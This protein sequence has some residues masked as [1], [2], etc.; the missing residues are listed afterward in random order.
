MVP[1]WVIMI[2]RHNKIHQFVSVSYSW[3]GYSY[4]MADLMTRLTLVWPILSLGAT[5]PVLSVA[6]T[7]WRAGYG[8]DRSGKTQK[9]CIMGSTVDYLQCIRTHA[10]GIPKRAL[11]TTYW[12]TFYTD[13][14][15][16]YCNVIKCTML[17]YPIHLLWYRCSNLEYH[18]Y[19]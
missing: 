7:A 5:G 13:T 14:L 6:T 16:L 4:V 2:L 15:M 11:Q 8:S 10:F 3:L 9:H 1:L 19:Q 17:C 18:I 12:S